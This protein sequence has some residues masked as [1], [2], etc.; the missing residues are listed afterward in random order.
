MRRCSTPS[1]PPS[2]PTKSG[3]NSA[4]PPPT[5]HFASLSAPLSTRAR[6]LL[7]LS[8]SMLAPSTATATATCLLLPRSAAA[9][10]GLPLHSLL[11]SRRRPRHRCAVDASSAAASGGGGAAK[12]PPRTLFPG[13][14]KRPE[15]Q[16]PALVLRV[17]VDE[18]LGSGDAVSAALARGVGIVVLEAG[19]EGG[20]RAYEAAR[21]LK[22]AV[23]DRAYLLIAERVDVASA[24]GASGVVLADDGI[25]AIVARSMMMKSNSDS[26]Y[27][28]LVA[29]TI[30]SSDSAR[31]ATSS[32]GADFLIV[33][34]GTGDFSSVLNGAGAQHV[35]IPVFFTLNDLQSEGSYSDTTS[36][37]FQSGA[38]GI[39]LSLTGIQ[40]LTDNIIER[41]FLKVDSTGTVPQATSSSAS[42]LEETNNVMV[43]TREKTK[44][45]GFTKLDEKV[46]QLIAMEKPILSEAVDV[47]RKAA[48]MMEEAELLVDAASRLSEPFLLVIVGEFNSG[49][50]TFINALLGRKYLQEGVVPTTNEITLLSY[51]EVDSE[52]ME[53]CERHPD[54]QFTCYLSAPILKEMNLVDTPGTNVILQ[55]QQRLT[56]EY[57]PR[58]DLILFVL[59]SDRPLTESEVGFLQYVQQW[60]K[61]VVFVLNK[62]D[63]YRN[64]D[65]LEEATAF[66]KENA[67]KLLNTED[68]TLFPVSSRSALEVKLSYSKKNDRE[69]HGEVL[70]SDPRWRSSK[71]YDL[72]HYLL[73]FLDGSTDTGKERV[74]LKLETPIGIADRLLTSCQRLVKLEHEKAIDDL[75]SIRDL[76]SGANNYALKIE[77]DSNSWQKQISSLIERAKSRAITL[78]ESTLQLSNIDLIFTYMLTGEKGPSA[79]ATSFVQN[80]ILSPALDDAAD[81]L[82]EY[83]K[84]LS[85]SNTREA[86]LYLEC[87]HE[88][89]NSLVSQ[90]ESVSSDRTELVNEGE[91]LSIKV[92]D[93]FSATAAAKVFEEEIR[94]VATGTFG[95]LGVAGLSASLLTSVLTTTLED[96]LALALCSA[97]GFFAISN[98]PGRRK[99]AV[100]KVSKAADEL[101]RKVDEAIQKDISQSGSKLVQFVDT[102]SKPYQEACQRKID[103][104]QG[105]QG[106]LS[107][108]ERKLQTLKID[109]QNLH[110]S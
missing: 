50:S 74:R 103:W 24:V 87:F 43:L 45:A 73:S 15:I 82:G 58:A 90:E 2:Y 29:R 35:K 72:E 110:G 28:P 6:A 78:M 85:S 70:L 20:G 36:K 9:S 102:A 86:N 44:V 60:K 56:E 64:S 106:E 40:H 11:L 3:T 63:L 96:L 93:G 75:T 38:S 55:R 39:V 108:V 53:R 52:S 104:L 47:I 5:P 19:E 54:G 31:S 76:V 46:M 1:R 42:A 84:W 8:L 107:A 26:I 68:V 91:K 92:L 89:W 51:S 99:L 65:E 61:K 109:I 66:I 69:H 30:R 34:T 95:G 62:L 41:D 10:R 100:E 17:G 7:S 94:E 81:L 71:F 80:D 88:R 97:G 16:V 105:V 48:P 14:F 49:K 83:S 37:L 59:S 79:K 33:N 67:R 57:V 23:G 32:E 12:E 18:A 25:P 98:F 13:G 101:S 27:L 77:A 21:A 22:A 4:P